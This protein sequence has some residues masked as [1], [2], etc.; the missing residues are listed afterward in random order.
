M[1]LGQ[2]HRPDIGTRHETHKRELRPFEIILYDDAPVAELVVEKHVPQSSLR[3][4]HTPGDDHPFPGRQAVVLEHRRQR[5]RCHV[6]QRLP[7]VVERTV[8]GRRNIVPYHQLLSELLARLDTGSGSG[9]PE[10]AKAMTTEFV[11]DSGLKGGFRSDHR[12]VDVLL[13][14]ES[15]QSLH[16]GILQRHILRHFRRTGI[17][18]CDI[19]LFHFR[20]TAKRI[21][22]RM[23]ASAAPYYK[24]FHLFLSLFVSKS[25]SPDSAERTVCRTASFGP[26][27][28]FEMAFASEYHGDTEFIGLTTESS[29]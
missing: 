5:P 24:H 2:R 12:Q 8:S 18:R 26:A 19:Y 27:S 7:V 14:R 15:Q 28:V 1:V 9:R 10:D 25:R 20:R 29:S 22:Y 16:V 21:R 23:A 4:L 6:V 11:H 3:L 13:L 17:A